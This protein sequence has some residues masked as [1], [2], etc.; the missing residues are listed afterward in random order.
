ME[1]HMF[2]VRQIESKSNGHGE[3]FVNSYIC[4][5]LAFDAKWNFPWVIIDCFFFGG[6]MVVRLWGVAT[7]YDASRDNGNAKTT[8]FAY[9][10]S[11]ENPE[12]R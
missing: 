5:K 2:V 9:V 7:F 12:K 8:L 3:A 4:K 1:V 10:K 6:G 11:N